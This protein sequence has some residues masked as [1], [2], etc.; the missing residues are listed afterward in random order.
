MGFALVLK[1]YG[2][3]SERRLLLDTTIWIVIAGFISVRD[4][5]LQGLRAGGRG[6][7]ILN[8]DKSQ[9]SRLAKIDFELVVLKQSTVMTSLLHFHVL[10]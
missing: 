10:G 9:W 3:I 7:T 6:D 2:T 4:H 8:Q 1:V 5:S